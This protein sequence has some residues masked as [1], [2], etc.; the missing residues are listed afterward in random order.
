M[1]ISWRWKRLHGS[2][3]PSEKGQGEA[4]GKMGGG[5]YRNNNKKLCDILKTRYTKRRKR[6]IIGIAIG[7][8]TENIYFMPGNGVRAWQQDRKPGF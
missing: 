3:N 1:G 8:S 5:I 7:L 2:G 4:A 6:L